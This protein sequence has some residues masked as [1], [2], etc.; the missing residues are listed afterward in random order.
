MTEVLICD[1][2]GEPGGFFVTPGARVL[3]EGCFSKRWAAAAE[4]ALEHA[5]AES[6]THTQA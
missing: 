6:E 3:C 2:C 4:R 5:G 1:D